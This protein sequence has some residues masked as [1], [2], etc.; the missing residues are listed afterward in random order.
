M[1]E[2]YTNRELDTKFQTIH[3]KLDLILAQ[4]TKTNGRVSSLENWRSYIVG[5]MAITTFVVLPLI[6]YIFNTSMNNIKAQI[7]ATQTK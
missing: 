5:G 6:I 7:R 1:E 3:E 2:Q 4:T